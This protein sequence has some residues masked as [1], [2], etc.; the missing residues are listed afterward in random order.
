M[1]LLITGIPFSSAFSYAAGE[2]PG[3]GQITLEDGSLVYLSFYAKKYEMGG[4][5]HQVPSK[6]TYDEASQSFKV[7]VSNERLAGPIY[8]KAE[9]TSG[10]AEKLSLCLNYT[11]KGIFDKLQNLNV[12]WN[13]ETP[14]TSLFTDGPT[15][16]VSKNEGTI[17]LKNGEDVLKTYPIT[18]F[19][20]AALGYL[21][22]KDGNSQNLSVEPFLDPFGQTTNY[23]VKNVVTDT[24]KIQPNLQASYTDEAI[25]GDKTVADNKVA[26]VTL[27]WNESGTAVIDLTVRG[28]AEYADQEISPTTYT[29]T[30]HK[31]KDGAIEIKTPPAKTEYREGE[32]FDK[33]GMVVVKAGTEEEITD[34]EIVTKGALKRGMTKVQL[35][36]GDCVIEQPVTVTSPFEQG[37]G[38]KENPYQISNQEDIVH[39]SNAVKNGLSFEQN[40]FQITT[41]I[42]LPEGWEP[43]GTDHA[44]SGYIDGKHRDGVIS[45][46]TVPENGLPLLGKVTNAGVKNLKIYGPKIA[47]FGVVNNYEIGSSIDFENVTLLEGTSTL[48]SGFIGG[49]ASGADVISITNCTVEK[50]VTIGYDGNENNIGSFGG[51]FNGNIINCKSYATVKGKNFVGGIVGSKG[52]T[53]AGQESS[54]GAYNILNC[55]FGGSVEATGDYVG[56]IAGSGYGG[57]RIGLGTA[58]NT[59]CAVIQNCISTG[60]VTGGNYVGG[61]LGAEPGVMQCWENGIGYIQNNLFTGTVSASNGSYVGGITGYMNSMNKFTVISNNFFKQQDNVKG[62]GEIKYIDTNNTSAHK[63]DGTIYINTEHSVPTG[64]DKLPGVIRT[65]HNRTDDPKGKD[66]D[67]LA[68]AVTDVQMKDGT[69]TDLLNSGDNSY[70]NWITGENG[71]PALSKDAVVYKLSLSGTYKT[72]YKTNES[73]DTNGMV[74]TATYTDGSVKNIAPEDCTF[75]GFDTSKA[76]DLRITVKYGAGKTNFNITVRYAEPEKATVSVTIYGDDKH[77]SDTDGKLHTLAGGGLQLWGSGTYEVNQ[78]TK[79]W[80]VLKSCM[81]ENNMTWENPDDNYIEY[82]TKNG[83]RIGEF[84]NGKNSGWMYTLNGT[85]PSLGVNQQFVKDG[86]VI[87]LHYT[88]DYTKEEGSDKWEQPEEE[89]P[90]SQDITASVSGK[91]ASA[92]VPAAEIDQLISDA[93]KNKA[94]IIDLNIK[95]ADKADKILVELPKASVQNI[96][97]KTDAALNINT[98][99]GNVTLDRRAMTEAV[100]AAAG[101]EITLILEKKAASDAQKAQLGDDAAFTDVKLLSGGKEITDLGT[102]KITVELPVSDTLAAKTC[103]L[104]FMD[105]DGKLTKLSGKVVTVNGKK[106]FRFETS[107]FGSFVLAEESK[108]DAAIKEQNEQPDHSKVIAGVK[109]TTI[110]A[111]SELNKHSVKLTWSKSKGYKVDQ[112]QVYRSRKKTAGTFKK[113][114]ETTKKTF[115]NET[116]LKKGTRYYYKVRGVRKIDGKNYYTKWSNLANR[117][118]K[119]NSLDFGVKATTVKAKAYA[120]KGSVKVSWTKSKGYKVDGYQ[121]Y[122]ADKKNGT[123]KKIAATKKTTLKNTKNLKKGRTYYYKVRGYR[124]LEGKKIYT[125]W[126]KVTSVKAK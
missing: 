100:K 21:T 16:H 65:G 55:E 60:S 122:R 108:L 13:N 97:D 25:I 125:K 85:H 36:Y 28:K 105:A 92:K 101:D 76:G 74:L 94:D 42:T 8:V 83:V 67:K 5:V 77:D 93:L 91:E 49:F 45:K 62:I 81:L 3:Q 54:G 115:T 90:V 59:P 117:T 69:V 80:D 17:E 50:G 106:Y 87:V 38:T 2:K 110:K 86:D 14:I 10:E 4:A 24:V 19:R 41:D 56:G 48:K 82:I 113:V 15:R 29:L 22:L 111:K 109:A 26:E 72:E 79:V 123:Y 61:I 35:Q 52:Q 119:A 23:E 107:V 32:A 33:T 68:K 9:T 66:A 99:L 43:I 102:A 89:K 51:D 46:I 63:D 7:I 126:S 73:L 114:A 18:F 44:F 118:M 121:V 120:S 103:A 6:V 104:A 30:F 88:D 75:E 96:A 112:Y 57:T 98:A 1:A 84:T 37:D 27:N 71:I 95:G 70:G 34:Y 12:S 124:Q 40:Y 116:E 47:G 58:P 20:Q 39:L 64:D 31:K 78:N 11:K 53:M